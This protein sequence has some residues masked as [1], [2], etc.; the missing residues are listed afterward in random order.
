MCVTD[1]RNIA[2]TPVDNHQV[3]LE[4]AQL[5]VAFPVFERMNRKLSLY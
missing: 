1:G 4:I 5:L 3:R 2:Q